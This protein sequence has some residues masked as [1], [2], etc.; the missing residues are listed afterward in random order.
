MNR[1]VNAVTKE[2]KAEG[3]TWKLI[4]VCPDSGACGFVCPV[5]TADHIPWE[6]SPGSKAGLKYKVANK[7]EIP[8][9]GQK[10]IKGTDKNGNRMKALWQGAPVS[11]PLAGVKCMNKANNRVV[12]DEENGENVSHI[13]N[14]DTGVKIPIDCGDNG[15]EFEMWV[16]EEEK[17]GKDL[18]FN[19]QVEVKEIPADNKGWKPVKKGKNTNAM[20][21]NMQTQPGFVRHA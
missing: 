1:E 9:I 14:K 8:N 21:A 5:E 2:V 15:F 18:A 12:F 6:E 4:K 3:G 17:K 16:F 20:P 11:K 7:Q 10:Y 13:L 19:E